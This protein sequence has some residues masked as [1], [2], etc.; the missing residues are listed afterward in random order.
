MIIRIT[1]HQRLINSFP[2]F[3]RTH[4]HTHVKTE[5]KYMP[6]SAQKNTSHYV[7]FL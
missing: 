5:K 6:H 1:L 3:V 4:T 2:V 7:Y